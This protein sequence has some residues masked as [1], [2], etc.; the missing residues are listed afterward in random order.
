VVL[1]P[2]TLIERLVALIPPPRKK[3]TSYH[4]VV[5]PAFPYTVVP[6]RPIGKDDSHEASEHLLPGCPHPTRGRPPAPPP[7]STAPTVPAKPRPK[8][9]P[10]YL[11]AELLPR[12]YLV[13]VLSCPH[14]KRTRRLLAFI[15]DPPVIGRIL[16]HL[17]LTTEPP[18]LATARPPPTTATPFRQP[19]SPILFVVAC[20]RPEDRSSHSVPATQRR[21]PTA[22]ER[23]VP[24]FAPATVLRCH[25]Y[26]AARAANCL[27]AREFGGVVPLPWSRPRQARAALEAPDN[28]IA[29]GPFWSSR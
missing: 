10:R 25:A 7:T 13:D 28:N 6:P 8:P 4:G 5:A 26:C 11:W 19:G 18:T 9:R 23:L 12:V 17:G 22:E 14:C 20:R 24:G 29:G 27:R 21:S 2:L 16:H 1:D 15:T 3:L